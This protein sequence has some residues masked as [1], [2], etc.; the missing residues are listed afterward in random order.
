MAEVTL[1]LAFFSGYCGRRL[2]EQQSLLS[3]P[4]RGGAGSPAWQPAQ[5]QVGFGDG[6]AADQ[7]EQL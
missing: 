7:L 4:V 5:A 6:G 2:H 1:Q 3:R